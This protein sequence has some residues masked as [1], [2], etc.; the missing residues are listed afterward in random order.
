MFLLLCKWLPMTNCCCRI[1]TASMDPFLATGPNNIA[2]KTSSR[3]QMDWPWTKEYSEIGLEINGHLM[4]PEAWLC[5][6][7]NMFEDLNLRKQYYISCGQFIAFCIEI[8][9]LQNIYAYF[10]KIYIV[11]CKWN[12]HCT[13][14]HLYYSHM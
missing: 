2:E 6:L 7:Q 10:A 4:M 8:A 1:C 12:G 3:L 5:S 14:A 13:D 11:S 9:S